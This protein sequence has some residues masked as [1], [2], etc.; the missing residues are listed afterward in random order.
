M[1]P[2]TLTVGGIN[3]HY[4]LARPG[5]QPAALVLALHGMGATAAWADDEAGWSADFPQMGF[6]LAI[7]EGLPPNPAKP[8]KFLT[9]PPRWGDLA[10]DGAADVA[11]LAAVVQDAARRADVDPLARVTG[12]SNGAGMAFRFAS[13][14]A[15]LVAAL[16][17]VAGH[18]WIDPKPSRPIPTL[19]MIG[20]DDPLVPLGGGAVKLPWA[21]RPAERP[22]VA[23]TLTRWAAAIGCDSR[24]VGDGVIPGPVEFRVRFVEG[25]G[26]HWPGGKGRLGERL[27]GPSTDRVHANEL[28]GEF[29]RSHL[30]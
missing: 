23:E 13:A 10:A 15:D 6:A 17:P 4:L 8:S 27:G 11:F 25:H 12:F 5:G 9:N 2:I 30:C 16:A 21:N 20:T 24:V 14:R 28:I 19:Y 22:P 26:H 7:P 18:C 3:R 1:E 29:F